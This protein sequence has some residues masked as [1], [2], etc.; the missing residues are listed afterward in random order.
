[1][2]S[3]QMELMGTPLYICSSL[4]A[5]RYLQ[6]E[7]T[8]KLAIWLTPWHWKSKRRNIILYIARNAAQ[9]WRQALSA[10]PTKRSQIYVTDLLHFMC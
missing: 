8:V 6:A 10:S 3:L 7:I 2:A 5:A 4:N 1:M 9:M